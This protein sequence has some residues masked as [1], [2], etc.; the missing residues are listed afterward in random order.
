ME[1]NI[2]DI[3]SR[4]KSVKIQG[5][6][7]IAIESLKFLRIY[8][9]KNGFGKK[10]FS[11]CDRL[12]KARPTAVVLHNCLNVIKREK[13]VES[14]N[15]ILR[16]LNEVNEGI[17]SKGRDLVKGKIMTHC[18]SGE[19][20]A[21]IKK[22]WADGKKIEVYATETDPLEQGVK[23][24]NEL[25][26]AGIPVTIITDSAA[27]YFMPEMDCVIVGTDAM[28][29]EGFVNKIGTYLLALAARDNRKP[30]YV[31]GDTMKID[32]RRKIVIE[33][34]PVKEIYR[35]LVRPVKKGVKVKNP[36]FDITPWKFVT[37]VITEKGVMTP[38]NL[39]K[40]I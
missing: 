33:E 29:K 17:A 21:V 32:R 3:I 30:F 20:L 7:E 23:T 16:F 36:A 24:A 34:R 28:R 39:K 6:K 4:I 18:H 26:K 13:T 40:L 12:E 22:A 10:F 2:N 14:I 38:G 31:V 9:R 19:A 15:R 35:E 8:A 25:A 11:V 5:A 37:R 27:G 1:D